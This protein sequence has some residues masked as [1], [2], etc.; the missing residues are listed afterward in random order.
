MAA[1]KKVEEAVEGVVEAVE[2]TDAPEIVVEQD[3]YT[4]SILA[5]AAEM[6]AELA[7]ADKAAA[8]RSLVIM[9]SHY[10]IMKKNGRGLQD[11]FGKLNEAGLLNGSST[12]DTS[13]YEGMSSMVEVISETVELLV[14]PVKA[15]QIR[16]DLEEDGV[17][18]V[19]V[20][21]EMMKLAEVVK[22]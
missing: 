11:V 22:A 2:A 1:K 15:K 4:A 17:R 14:G 19:M 5:E 10:N 16:E 7:A 13:T 9:L 18:L 3:E 6:E 8:R 12:I 20:F 21:M